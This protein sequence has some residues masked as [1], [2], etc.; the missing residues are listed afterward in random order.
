MLPCYRVDQLV[1]EANT[2]PSNPLPLVFE[3][4]F[5]V[6]LDD[7]LDLVATLFLWRE[8]GYS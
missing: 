4:P 6:V 2:I 1:L 8:M 7:E 5:Q 3:P